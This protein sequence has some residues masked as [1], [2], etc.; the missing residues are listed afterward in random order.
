M[1]TLKDDRSFITIFFLTLITFGIYGIY[2]IHVQ[3]RDTNIACAEDGKKTAGLIKL[4]LIGIIT[5]GI[6]FIVWDIKL[7][8]RWQK[9]TEKNNEKP[10]CSILIHILLTFVLSFTGV[11]PIIDSYLRL[12]AFNQVCEI[13]NLTGGKT[14]NTK[15]PY[16]VENLWGW[17]DSQSVKQE[18]TKKKDK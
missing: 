8:L 5:F 2:F 18:N 7:V 3:A 13:Y 9:Y 14:P 12:R 6:Y 15:N 17:K 16:S 1:N 11:A 10:R 4:I